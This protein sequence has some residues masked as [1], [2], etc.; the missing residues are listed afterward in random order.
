M[1]CLEK[2]PSR[3]YGS[4]QEL[5]DDLSR[6]LAGEPVTAQHVGRV[7][8]L[9]RLA[10][11]NRAW[12]LAIVISILALSL[13][14]SMILRTRWTAHRTALAS[15]RFGQAVERIEGLLQRAYLSPLHDL[16]PEIGEVRER[17]RWIEQEMAR[18][19]RFLSRDRALCLGA[20]FSGAR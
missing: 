16:R 10:R 20:G 13:T 14:A 12:T 1:K 17:M 19:G 3:R 15:Q 2:R 18:L 9:G 11:R 5:A 7:R 8:R 4:A 6:F